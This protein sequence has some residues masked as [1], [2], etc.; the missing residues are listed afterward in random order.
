MSEFV[1]QSACGALARMRFADVVA[2]ARAPGGDA[3]PTVEHQCALQ[4][5]HPGSHQAFAQ[6]GPVPDVEWWLSWDT[7]TQSRLDLVPGCLAKAA[8]TDESGDTLCLLPR[9]HAAGHSFEF[10]AAPGDLSPGHEGS[11]LPDA[12]TEL[13]SVC[14]TTAAETAAALS[15]LLNTRTVSADG[16][17]RLSRTEHLLLQAMLENWRPPTGG[18]HSRD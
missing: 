7:G 14:G 10:P 4:P 6:T 1:S 8:G 9:G 11:E 15:L 16:L 12:L 5:N 3:V 13:L 17:A 18:A 2:M